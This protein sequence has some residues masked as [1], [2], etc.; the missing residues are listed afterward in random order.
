[1]S[2]VDKDNSEFVEK[3]GSWKIPS[4][5]AVLL[6]LSTI[7]LYCK[8]IDGVSYVALL[9]LGGFGILIYKLLPDI[10]ALTIAGHSINLKQKLNEAEE[11]TRQLSALRDVMVKY[12]LNSIG[13]FQGSEVKDTFYG[14]SNLSALYN[15]FYREEVLRSENK[16]EFSLVAEIIRN[17]CIN[18][19]SFKIHGDGLSTREHVQLRYNELS[20][21]DGK[22]IFDINEVKDLYF[23][24]AYILI[25]DAINRIQTGEYKE[26][27][28][29][30]SAGMIPLL[31]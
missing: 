19:F 11:I 29:P 21:K 28:V 2:K 27:I 3:L 20:S 7:L 14:I 17:R 9:A 24:N 31:H 1:M 13:V 22:L 8:M 25:D 12:T 6:I 30:I 16:D 5:L 26:L 15:L 23:A 18:H 4:L 10:T